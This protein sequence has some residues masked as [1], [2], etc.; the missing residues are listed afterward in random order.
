M[1]IGLDRVDCITFGA[2]PISTDRIKQT[3]ENS[4]FLSIIND[5]DPVV[6]AQTEYLTI[7]L[8][9]YAF[10]LSK[11]EKAHPGGFEV[12]RLTFKVSGQCVVL[13]EKDWEMQERDKD[14][15]EAFLVRPE[16]VEATLFA[17]FRLH[18]KLAYFHRVKQLASNARHLK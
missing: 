5:G 2:P 12:P 18:S 8:S 17:N 4:V 6:L 10:S 11:W 1:G 16:V 7:L 3:S 14:I 15:I 9:L 13:R